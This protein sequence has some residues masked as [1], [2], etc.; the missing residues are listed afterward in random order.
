MSKGQ[1]LEL[2]AA[3][4]RAQVG[5]IDWEFMP[6]QVPVAIPDPIP[7]E[8]PAF[9]QQ[10][11]KIPVLFLEIL[12]AQP[13]VQVEQVQAPLIKQENFSAYSTSTYTPSNQTH[14]K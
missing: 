4:F 13:P 8:V 9:I 10:A 12:P 11:A 5:V 7:A 2:T 3:Y 1:D 6:L 14:P